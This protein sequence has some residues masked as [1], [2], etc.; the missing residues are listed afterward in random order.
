M[1]FFEITCSVYSPSLP[2]CNLLSLSFFPLSF[3][4]YCIVSSRCCLSWNP[5]QSIFFL[6]LP[7]N[8]RKVYFFGPK[9]KIG[10]GSRPKPCA[11][12]KRRPPSGLHNRGNA[13]NMFPAILSWSATFGWLG[14]RHNQPNANWL[15]GPLFQ[16]SN[17]IF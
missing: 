13:G 3:K 8:C 1:L 4:P 11:G 17:Y 9:N 16:P 15:A 7:E 12:G 5:S 6:K 14:Q 10:L 2:S